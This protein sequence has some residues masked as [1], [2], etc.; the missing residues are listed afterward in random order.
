MSSDVVARAQE[1]RNTVIAELS[2][3]P[4]TNSSSNEDTKWTPEKLARFTE[5]VSDLL[6]TGWI[7]TD[8]GKARYNKFACAQVQKTAPSTSSSSPTPSSNQS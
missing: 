5:L 8:S 7:H 1:S 4:P 6:Q 3:A 2:K